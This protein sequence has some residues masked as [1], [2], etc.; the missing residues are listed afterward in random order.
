MLNAESRNVQHRAANTLMNHHDELRAVMD[1]PRYLFE[2]LPMFV[3]SQAN[4]SQI[5]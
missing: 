5:A 4:D 3:L 1:T 2:T